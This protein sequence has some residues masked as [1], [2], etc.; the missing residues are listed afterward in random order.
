MQV[1]ELSRRNKFSQNH[2]FG[3][4]YAV[5]VLHADVLQFFVNF[6]F[7]FSLDVQFGGL[8]FHFGL[9]SYINN[10]FTVF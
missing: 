7:L 8:I 1:P 10:F 4:Q 5:I 6:G 9:F 2:N 3:V